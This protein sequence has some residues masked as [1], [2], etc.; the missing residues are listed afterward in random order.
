[1][2][3]FATIAGAFV[4][5]GRL[6]LP[7]RGAWHATLV[8]DTDQ[9]PAGAVT[10]T[11]D[12]GAVSW[13]GAVVPGRA[14]ETFGRVEVLVVG[15]AGG[16][17]AELAPKA[18]RNVSARSV[19][20]DLLTAAGETLSEASDAA[21]LATRFPTWTR[22]AGPAGTGLATVCEAIEG[23][24]R[25]G[26]DGAVVI[27]SNAAAGVATK[28]KG[29]RL[30]DSPAEAWARY[31]LERLDLEPGQLLEGR[32]VGRIEHTLEAGSIRS[33]VWFDG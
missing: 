17:G 11:T 3:A 26:L 23:G 19:L 4:L 12:E 8:L 27:S 29:V 22:F 7:R 13:R 21:L 15:G 31:A 1:M 32:R 6:A 5:Q 10:F 33:E 18:Y 2:T 20:A 28:T 14:R 16:L 30:A 9:P 25:V 24:W